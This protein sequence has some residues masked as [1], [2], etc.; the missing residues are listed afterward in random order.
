MNS[1]KTIDKAYA[2]VPREPVLN[3]NML[4]FIPDRALRY[5]WIKFIRFFTR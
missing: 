4:D 1:K 3:T 2:N 5:Y